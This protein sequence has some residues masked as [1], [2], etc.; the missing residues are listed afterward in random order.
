MA[1]SDDRLWEIWLESLRASCSDEDARRAIAE[2]ARCEAVK[3]C[4]QVGADAVLEGPGLL[5]VAELVRD[6]IR[7]LLAAD[8]DVE[9]GEEQP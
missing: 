9:R 5:Y 7:A 8:M 1:L 6:A 3:E 4:A 2:A